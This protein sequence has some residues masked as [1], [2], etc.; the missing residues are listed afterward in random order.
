MAFSEAELQDL[1]MRYAPILQH[2]ARSILGSDE[3]AA[4]AVQDTFARVLRSPDSFRAESSPLTWLYRINT[5]LCLN[6]LRDRQGHR[7]K[8]HDHREEIAGP[9]AVEPEEPDLDAD[10]VRALLGQ[11]DE[12]TRRIVLHLYFDDMTREEAAKMVGISLPTLRKRLDQFFVRARRTLRVALPLV[13]A[14]LR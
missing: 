1:Y 3:E 8:H 6:R 14:V 2:R 10:R 12:E 5:N 7:R 9:E 13:L 11:A 4:D